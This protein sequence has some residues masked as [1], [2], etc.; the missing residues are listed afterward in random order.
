MFCDCPESKRY[1]KIETVSY[2][3]CTLCERIFWSATDSKDLI[4]S[5]ISLTLEFDEPADLGSAEIAT[6]LELLSWLDALLAKADFVQGTVAVDWSIFD[7]EE[8]QEQIKDQEIVYL[9]QKLS[10]WRL[11]IIEDG[12]EAHEGQILR[13]DLAIAPIEEL[14]K[15]AMKNLWD[16]MGEY[17]QKENARSLADYISEKDFLNLKVTCS[18]EY[19]NLIWKLDSQL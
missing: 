2:A 13:S 17:L 7:D 1:G 14:L 12:E 11:E 18:V 10:D 19:L 3:I 5:E 9:S 4:A 16:E 6:R 8:L 15:V